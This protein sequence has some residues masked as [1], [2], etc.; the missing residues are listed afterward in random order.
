MQL[1]LRQG[2]A[3]GDV[4]VGAATREHTA[5]RSVD[6]KQHSL[7]GGAFAGDGDVDLGGSGGFDGVEL[8]LLGADG[9]DRATAL[10]SW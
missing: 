1:L 10:R 7:D 5:E 6:V 2:E 4:D 3:L 8:G 9:C